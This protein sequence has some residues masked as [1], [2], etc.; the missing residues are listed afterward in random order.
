MLPIVLSGEIAV[1]VAGTGEGLKRRLAVVEKAG[2]SQPTVFSDRLPTKAEIAELRILFIAG[3]PEAAAQELAFAAREVGTLV[4]VE[5]VPTLCDFHVPAQ[6]RRGDLLFTIS[7]AGRSPGLARIL[8]ERIEAS[9]G[10]EWEARLDE[11]ARARE[12]W[13]AEGLKPEEVAARTRAM[14]DV[15]GWLA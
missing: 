3:L 11:L 1:G 8:R 5:D 4:N 15:R 12:A 7:T 9:F 10:P 2:M 13:R 6:I 14:L